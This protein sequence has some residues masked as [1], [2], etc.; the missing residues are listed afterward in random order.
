MFPLTVLIDWIVLEMLLVLM[1]VILH[2]LLWIVIIVW[3]LRM[4]DAI[5]HQG[6]N[7]M[8][9]CM[10]IGLALAGYQVIQI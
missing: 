9:Y 5:E 7:L 4:I 10:I 2:S 3:F 1:S 8:V 6:P